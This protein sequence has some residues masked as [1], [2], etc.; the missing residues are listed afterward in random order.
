MVTI[1]ELRSRTSDITGLI[2]MK[3][4]TS[5]P[6]E[7]QAGEVA[8]LLDE[9]VEPRPLWLTSTEGPALVT[10]ELVAELSEKEVP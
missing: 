7:R 5:M 4:C 2:V 3:S 9:H 6:R 1:G 10:Q 8:L